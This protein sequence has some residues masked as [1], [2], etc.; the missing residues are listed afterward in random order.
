MTKYLMGNKYINGESFIEVVCVIL[1]L[2]KEPKSAMVIFFSVF[3]ILFCLKWWTILQQLHTFIIFVIY[4]HAYI[5]WSF[6]HF[7]QVIW[8]VFF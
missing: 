8:H 6:S 3:I 4:F 5:I 2:Y 7:L 1:Y